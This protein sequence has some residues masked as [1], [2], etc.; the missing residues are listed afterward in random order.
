ME[1]GV[2]PAWPLTPSNSFIDVE[3]QGLECNTRLLSENGWRGFLMNGKGY[4]KFDVKEEFITAEN[5]NELFKKYNVP[6]NFDLLSIDLDFNDYWIWKAIKGYSPRVVV[7]E[8]NA[9]IP[10]NVS[11]VIKYDPKGKWDGTNYFG[12]SLL[13]LVKLAKKK[14]YTLI[15]CDNSG[16]NAFFVRDDMVKDNFKVRSIEELYKPPAY[17]Y[18]PSD[19]EMIDV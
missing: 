1:F 15:G 3:K 19:K 7:I 4:L 5:I 18:R 8:Y 11:K 16:I 17:G 2:G 14:G 13:A 9:S 6:T 12:A 10:V